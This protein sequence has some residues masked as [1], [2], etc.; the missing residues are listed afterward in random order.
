M[1]EPRSP[2]GQPSKPSNS[3]RSFICRKST[4]QW[5][6]KAKRLGG[7]EMQNVRR[8]RM[9][10]AGP[11]KADNRQQTL[12]GGANQGRE[13]ILNAVSSQP[14]TARVQVR[15]R[16]YCVKKVGRE[17]WTP[18]QPD[19][20][21]WRARYI[22]HSAWRARCTRQRAAVICFPLVH[23][24]ISPFAMPLGVERRLPTGGLGW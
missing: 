15:L 14:K 9:V 7:G 13:R 2:S 10:A 5:E 8:A 21:G 18:L 17:P 4:S 20:P 12:A 23:G 16:S 3:R 22:A 1:S 24:L 19:R 6:N 11:P